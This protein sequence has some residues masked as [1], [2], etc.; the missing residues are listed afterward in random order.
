MGD[1]DTPAL[2]V[3]ADRLG[4]NLASMQAAADR[5]GLALRPHAKTHKCAAVARHQ[6]AL[7]AC[8]LTVATVGE[9]EHFAAA[10]V[11]DL[12]IAYPLWADARRG[13]RLATLA[14]RV[15]LLVGVDSVAGAR[16]LGR[17]LG[18]VG[19][20]SLPA[21]VVEVDSG[22]HRSGVAPGRAGLIARAAAD[23]ELEVA[24]V[25]TFPGHAYGPG[26]PPGAAADEARALDE[27]ST[28]L[29]DAGLPCPIR[30]G[31]STPTAAMGDP[32]VLTELRPG[33]YAFHDAQQLRLGTCTPAQVAL[34]VLATVVSAPA[35]GRLVLDAGSKALGADRPDWMVGH[36][37]LPGL[38]GAVVTALSEHHA[39]VSLD[40]A[41][42][43]ATPSVGSRVAVV[44][45]HV[46]AAVNLADELVVVAD[47]AAVDRWP[48]AGRAANR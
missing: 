41:A 26:A 42:D 44:P 12:F 28:A 20:P 10:G 16:A 14:R 3:D 8:G 30:S 25:F 22:Q 19:G 5:R 29:A 37:L 38:P 11:D 27:A 1:V 7:G 36:G 39:V 2:V 15:R 6:I 13:S 45:N 32:A 35:P 21:A 46:C 9:A 23:A 43:A 40:L 17:T 34:V 48:L 18:R 47:G 4:A 24:G 31:G 33:V